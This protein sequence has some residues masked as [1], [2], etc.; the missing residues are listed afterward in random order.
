MYFFLLRSS[1]PTNNTLNTEIIYDF[2][3][4]AIQFTSNVLSWGA[5]QVSEGMLFAGWQSAFDWQSYCKIILALCLVLIAV[6][7]SFYYSASAF[8]AMQ[9]ARG[10]LSVRPSVRT[11]VTFRYCVQTNEDM[12]MR[13]S[14]S[15]RTILAVSEEVKFIRIF[16][17]DRPQ[18]R[19]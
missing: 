1:R 12:I 13:F 5:L 19:R 15:G 16:A 8:L 2:L 6:C 17:G 9:R 18:R 3:I 4:N 10:I 14:A 7:Q 11:S